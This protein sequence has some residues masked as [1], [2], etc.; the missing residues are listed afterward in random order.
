MINTIIVYKLYT[1]TN[2]HHD[3]NIMTCYHLYHRR[4][5]DIIRQ[6]HNIYG[7][8]NNSQVHGRNLIIMLDDYKQWFDSWFVF[9]AFIYN[10]EGA[11][12]DIFKNILDDYYIDLH[13]DKKRILYSKNQCYICKHQFDVFHKKVYCDR[14]VSSHYF[15]VRCAKNKTYCPICDCK[16]EYGSC[17]CSD[18]D[19]SDSDCSCDSN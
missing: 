19:C 12:M 16:L 3:I 6:Q 14:S 1:N 2:N 15:C 7:N 5:F 9:F 8:V 11:W 4:Y 17:D 13:I 10:Q 18:S